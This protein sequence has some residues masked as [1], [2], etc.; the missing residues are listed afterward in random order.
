MSP[1]KERAVGLGEAPGVLQPI[2][3]A[4]TPELIAGML[5]EAVAS[6]QYAPGQ[7]LSEKALAER[8]GVSRGPLR[9]AMQRLTQEG[10]LVSHRNRGLFV[11][12]LDEPVIRDIYL[13]R[14]AVER[15][16]VGH[17]IGQGRGVDAAGLE[18]IV[19]RMESL[20]ADDPRVSDA[21]MEYHQVLVGL[22]ASPR[23]TRMHNTLVT[24][25]RLCLSLMQ[26]TYDTV[27]HRV[28]EHRGLL[29][30]IAAGDA[31]QADQ[32]LVAHMEDGLQRVLR[33]EP[34]Q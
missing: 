16:A 28:A 5:R 32:L 7:Q 9:E 21:D 1:S 10:L 31:V 18:P 17:L 26:P 11:M 34:W 29:K 14:L 24:Q 8:L 6:G 19:A 30:A 25:M 3:Q 22:A 13:A 12:Q 20:A 4:S 15:A 2:V 33:V 27:D 23:L